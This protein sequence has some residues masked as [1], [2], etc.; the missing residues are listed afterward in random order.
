MIRVSE[1]LAKKL[2]YDLCQLFVRYLSG[3]RKQ[4][5]SLSRAFGGHSSADK[6]LGQLA[7]VVKLPS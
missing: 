5:W 6:A 7:Q 1:R 3:V 4:S 2:S